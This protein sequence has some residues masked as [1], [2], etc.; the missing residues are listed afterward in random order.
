MLPFS[1]AVHHVTS[2]QACH[3]FLLLVIWLYSATT[4][5]DIVKPA[6]VEISVNTNGSY[7]V[8]VRASVEALLTGINARY[9]D[10]RDSPDAQ[11]YDELRALSADELTAAFKPFETE[12]TRQ[13]KLMFDGNNAPL[14]VTRVEIPEP[15]YTKVPRI[16]VIYLEGSIERSIESVS[17]YYPERFGDNAVRVRQVDEAREKWH[18][19][20]WQW[21]RDDEHSEPFSLTEV[22][23]RSPPARIIANYLVLGFEHILPGGLDHI[24]FILGIFLFSLRVRPVLW[25]V[26]MFTVAHTITLGL[27]M[28]GVISLPS[29]IVEPLIA[30]SI[31][32]IGIENIFARSLHN[33]RLVLVFCFGLLH[34][35]G[36][37]SVL[38]D[39]GMPENAF[40]TALI[41]FNVGVE[42]GQ[43]AV[44]ALAFFAVGIWFRN[45]PWYRQAIVI[46]GS[47]AIAITGLYWTYD[48]IML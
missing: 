1:L 27:T 14:T 2:K 16:S 33:S 3:G 34:G 5:A 46:P 47:L 21:L 36:F 23:T 48:R 25:Q 24:L 13:V 10:T 20:E 44:I 30:L 22:F 31:A 7:R 29:S 35:M 12:F 8:E 11:A 18:W 32:Y 17:W 6:L 9:K 39:F 19:S 26:T 38:S 41:S 45:K 40:V 28:Y 43:I 37:A 42:L 4:L 15:G